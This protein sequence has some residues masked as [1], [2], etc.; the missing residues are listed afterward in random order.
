MALRV[1]SER[2]TSQGGDEEGEREGER[3]REDR[4][5]RDQRENRRGGSWERGIGVEEEGVVPVVGDVRE[6]KADWREDQGREGVEMVREVRE[7]SRGRA[8]ERGRLREEGLEGGGVPRGLSRVRDW[9][10]S[11]REQRREENREKGRETWERDRVSREEGKGGRVDRDKEDKVR[12]IRGGGR[13][14]KDTPMN[15]SL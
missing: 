2:W 10:P 8:W 1:Y 12:D 4:E 6:V 3:V 9:R 5:G 7:G 14:G 15:D 11:G 13:G